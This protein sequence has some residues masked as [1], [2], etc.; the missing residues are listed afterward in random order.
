MIDCVR[1]LFEETRQRS[2]GDLIDLFGECV[3][4]F[5]GSISKEDFTYALL[6]RLDI[7]EALA[8]YQAAEARLRLEVARQYPDIT[9][10][11]G[12]LWDQGDLVWS[13]GAAILAPLFDINQ[14]PI[15]EAEA[16]RVLERG[17]L[18]LDPE[19]HT[20]HW[21][22]KPVTLTVT[23]FL[24]LQALAARPPAASLSDRSVSS[25]ISPPRLK[26]P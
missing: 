20:C 19:R 14:G 18:K 2:E 6:N 9:L 26:L 4:S 16:A 23:E 21:D 7:R 3:K 17:M 8:R 15:G 5:D 24:I 12:F 22:S 1:K 10:S 13:V 11:P 25:A